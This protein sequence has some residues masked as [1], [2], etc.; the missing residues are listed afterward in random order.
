M[1][2]VELINERQ[3]L[4][5]PNPFSESTTVYFGEGL[6]ENC[7]LQIVDLL[8]N[9]VYF[10]DRIIGNSIEIQGSTFNA[11]VYILIVQDSATSEIYTKKLVVN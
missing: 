1:S 7:S 3:I 8:G 5:Y 10:L 11:G 6:S 4:V 9:Q 2:I